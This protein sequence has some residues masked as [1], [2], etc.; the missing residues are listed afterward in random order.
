MNL[1]SA[2]DDT[3]GAAALVF[4]VRSPTETFPA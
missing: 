1:V 2:F 3:A 4:I